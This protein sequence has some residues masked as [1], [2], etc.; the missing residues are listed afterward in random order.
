MMLNPAVDR[1]QDAEARE[2][3]RRPAEALADAGTLM[4][5]AKGQTLIEQNASHNDIYLLIAGTYRM[6]INVGRQIPRRLAPDR[7]GDGASAR[8]AQFADQAAR[9]T[10][11]VA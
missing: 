9:S 6:I 5:V 11:A 3:D 1:A 7:A 8:T 2:R 4:A 10:S